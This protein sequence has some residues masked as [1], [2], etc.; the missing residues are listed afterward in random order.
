M[1][2]FKDGKQVKKTV[3]LKSVKDLEKLENKYF[4]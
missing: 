1:I 2:Y 4:Q 3:G